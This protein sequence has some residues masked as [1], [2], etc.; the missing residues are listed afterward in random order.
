M[1]SVQSTWSRPAHL[2]TTTPVTGWSVLASQVNLDGMLPPS[3]N[4]A[5]EIV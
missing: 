3:V 5:A 2:S 4:A 1:T